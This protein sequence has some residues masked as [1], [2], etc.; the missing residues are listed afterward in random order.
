MTF[1]KKYIRYPKLLL[2]ALT[3][4]IA[5]ELFQF[6]V[7][8]VVAETLNHHGYASMFLAGLLF[9][10]GFTTA[11]AI[12]FFATLAGEVNIFAGALIGGLGAVTSDLIIFRFIRTSFLDEFKLLK[13]NPVIEKILHLTKNS[14]HPKIKR[15][16]SIGLAGL[17]IASPLPDE[18]GVS[19]LSGLT[20]INEKAFSVIAFG[21]NT[22]G[23]ALMLHYFDFIS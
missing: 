18:L 13:H 5:Y 23:I 2:L 19:I 14:F 9:S 20:K 3:M 11:F 16:L 8:E 12:G 1:L 4:V 6:Q 10:Y 17:I 21:F 7:F 15:W 22:A